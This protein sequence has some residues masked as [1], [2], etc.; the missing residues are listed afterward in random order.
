MNLFKFIDPHRLLIFSKL[1][2]TMRVQ[3]EVEAWVRK[4]KLVKFQTK[5]LLLSWCCQHSRCEYTSCG[6]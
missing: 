4:R 1:N 2:E 3:V 6:E 5:D